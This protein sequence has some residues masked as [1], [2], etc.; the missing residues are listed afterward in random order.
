MTKK[1]KATQKSSPKTVQGNSINAQQQKLAQ[2]LRDAGSDGVTTIQ[3]REEHDV[4]AP[5]PRI[6]E[7]RHNHGLNI[8]CVRT[9]EINAQGNPHRCARYVLFPGKWGVA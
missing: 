2:A 7:L 5:A 4:M 8:Q 1:E 9:T 3:A 6:F